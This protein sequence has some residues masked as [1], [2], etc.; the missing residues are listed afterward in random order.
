ML[1]FRCSIFLVQK[2]HAL[3]RCPILQHLIEADHVRE[4]M[5]YGTLDIK[6]LRS[7]NSTVN[8]TDDYSD[9]EDNIG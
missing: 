3:I 5:F 6:R 7:P 4:S 1:G 2:V 9:H 8:T